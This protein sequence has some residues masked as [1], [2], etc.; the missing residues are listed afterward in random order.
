MQAIKSLVIGLGVLIVAG[1]VLLGYAFYSRMNDPDFKLTKSQTEQSASASASS[2]PAAAKKD[3]FGEASLG[4]PEGCGVLE[5]RPDGKLL[6]LRIGPPG[7]CE[8]VLVVESSS[9]RVRGTIVNRP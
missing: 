8:R 3:G 9:G 4:L 7:P 5:M 1:I 6:Y 2:S